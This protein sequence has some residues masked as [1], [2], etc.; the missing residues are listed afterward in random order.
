MEFRAVCRQTILEPSCTSLPTKSVLYCVVV[1]SVG[2][3][4][5]HWRCCLLTGFQLRKLMLL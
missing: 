2:G 4:T 1:A 3:P 5:D